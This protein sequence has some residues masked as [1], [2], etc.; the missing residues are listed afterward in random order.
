VTAPEK[1]FEH[2][3]ENTARGTISGTVQAD[4]SLTLTRYYDRVSYKGLRDN[5]SIDMLEIIRKTRY[6][7]WG[8]AYD[9]L[10]SIEP[11][12]HDMLLAGNG[13]ISSLAASAKK[14]VEKLIDKTMSGL[15]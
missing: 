2:F 5:D 7:N 12:V 10:G 6:Y 15:K 3:T 8:L 9:W 4:N 13:N 11:S 1:A 14:I